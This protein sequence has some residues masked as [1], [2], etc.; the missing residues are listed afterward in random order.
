VAD[1]ADGWY[2]PGH[3]VD[4]L[5]QIEASMTPHGNLVAG[6]WVPRA[7]TNR[8]LN[9]SNLDDVGGEYA[10]ADAA[11]ANRAIAAAVKAAPGWARGN[12]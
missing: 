6:E 5:E 3:A 1:R 7:D 11:Q 8:N 2:A 12:I 10:R 4:H 9:P